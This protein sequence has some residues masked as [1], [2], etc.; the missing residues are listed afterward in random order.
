MAVHDLQG[1]D[2]VLLVHL[3]G[4]TAADQVVCLKSITF[5][6]ESSEIDGSSFCGPNTLQGLAN[7]GID[8][9]AFVSYDSGSGKIDSAPLYV[10]KQAKTRISWK[11]TRATPVTGDPVKSGFGYI[12]SYTE[13]YSL[14]EFTGFSGKIKIDGDVT[15]VITI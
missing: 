15:Q 3:T 4:G 2:W 7:E 6:S 9:D 12:I 13:S 14:N 11:I 5:N 1:Q 8:F 10:A